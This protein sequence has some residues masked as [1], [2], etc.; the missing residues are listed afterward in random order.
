M[1]YT[2]LLPMRFPPERN[3]NIPVKPFRLLFAPAAL[4]IGSPLLAGAAALEGLLSADVPLAE[5]PE[6]VAPARPSPKDWTVLIYV[7]ARNNL[8]LEAIKDV[9]EMEAAGSTSKVN[10]V[11][12]MARIH[13]E[14]VFNPFSDPEPLPPQADWT[15]SR[16]FL[17]KKDSDPLKIT[18]PVLAHFPDADM[19]DWRHL[20][21]FISWGKANFPARKYLLIVGGHGSGWHG[22]KP[23]AQKGISY[24]EPSGNHISPSELARAIS[25]GGGVDVYASDACLMQTVETVYALRDAAEYV[26]GSQET[27]PGS[28]YNYE[29]FLKTLASDPGDAFT[30]AQSIMA[31][32]SEF[33]GAQNK[34]V[35]MS[36]VRPAAA[37]ELASRLDRFSL[38]V[39]ASPADL[40]LY[41][42][43]RFSLRD[44]EDK[45]A[46]D[47]Y[48]LLTLFYEKS[49]TPAVREAAKDAIIF[50]AREVVL[51]NDAV[52]Y[53][54][55]DANGL[56]VYFPWY[57]PQYKEKYDYLEFSADTSWNEMLRA[58]AEFRNN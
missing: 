9:N 16:R 50:L 28:G 10:V 38:L 23:P 40:G 19:G 58:A 41:W 46:R 42:E 6:A 30:A 4:L 54:S 25:A 51:R 34:S 26:V 48:Q 13:T 43:K 45:D 52:G 18:S 36:I 15:G 17:I 20:A 14:P 32:F 3:Y 55:K 56:S 44:F 39:A 5:V 21:E 57:P 47:L 12:E 49:P 8:G 29:V 11:T 37:V 27:S 33:Y 31:G 35:T 53:K 7:S 22:V 24:D 2:D 1:Q